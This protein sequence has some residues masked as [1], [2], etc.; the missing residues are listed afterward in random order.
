MYT[1]QITAIT[2]KYICQIQK[3]IL[4][5][6]IRKRVYKVHSTSVLKSKL[7]ASKCVL[8]NQQKFHHNNYQ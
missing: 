3:F 6:K 1:K 4:E 5:K 2:T 7:A 8:N